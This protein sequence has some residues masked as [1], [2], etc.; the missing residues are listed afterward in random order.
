MKDVFDYASPLWILGRIAD[1]VVLKN[2]MKNLLYERNR[3]IKNIAES[4]EWRKFLV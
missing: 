3:L 2:Y 1:A 4:E